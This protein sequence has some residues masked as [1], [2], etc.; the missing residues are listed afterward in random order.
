MKKMIIGYITG[1]FTAVWLGYY[2]L[3]A[4]SENRL[5]G[6][7]I[8]VIVYLLIYIHLAKLYKAFE[9]DIYQIGEIIFSQMLAIGIANGFAYIEC[10]LIARGYISIFPGILTTVFQLLGVTVWAVAAKRDFIQSVTAS[11]T[12]VVYGR[13]DVKEFCEK[14]A[15]KYSYLFE[16]GECVSSGI[17]KTA[18]YQKIDQYETVILYEVEYGTRTET[19]EYCIQNTKKIYITPRIA[20]IVIQGFCSSTLVDTPLMRYGYKYDQPRTYHWKRALDITVSAALFC[21]FAVPMLLTAIAIKIEDGGPV[22]FRQKRCTKGG[23]VFEI[24]KFRSMIVDAEKNGAVIPCIDHDPRITRVGKIIRR[25]RIDEMPQVF[26]VLKGEMSIVGPRPERVEHVREYTKEFPEFSYRLRVNGGLTGYA[27]IFGKY[28]TGAAD[29]LKLDLM[30]I[31]NQSLLLDLKL[32]MMTLKIMFIPES[33]E[34]FQKEK[35]RKIGRWDDSE[36]QK[37]GKKIV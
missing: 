15:K 26:N 1:M 37:T 18:L 13:N 31:E 28:N 29:K 34:G 25:Y 35:S 2:N 23:R 6:G 27:Q 22:F 8:S 7:I 36:L 16:I 11:R 20:D 4:F 32:I 19:M 24:L 5:S 21:L 3:F 12:L 10:C 30:Y 9:V 17:E 14:L 33:T